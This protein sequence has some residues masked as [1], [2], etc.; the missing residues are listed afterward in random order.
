MGGGHLLGYDIVAI[1][2]ILLLYLKR[3]GGL[4]LKHRLLL[5]ILWYKVSI[6]TSQCLDI[7]FCSLE[8]ESFALII[9]W[10]AQ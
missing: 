4:S 9:N 1:G 2:A 5:G 6:S 7:T 8:K 3:A 10:G